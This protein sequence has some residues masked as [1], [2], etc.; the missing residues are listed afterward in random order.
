MASILSSDTCIVMLQWPQ[1]QIPATK[2]WRAHVMD[3]WFAPYSTEPV[4]KAVLTEWKDTNWNIYIYISK[5]ECSVGQGMSKLVL[6]QTSPLKG[7][8]RQG[9]LTASP[10]QTPCNAFPDTA[11]LGCITA[12]ISAWASLGCAE[13]ASAQSWN[14]HCV[15]WENP[16]GAGQG[17]NPLPSSNPAPKPCSC[18]NK[19]DVLLTWEMQWDFCHGRQRSWGAGDVSSSLQPKQGVVVS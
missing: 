2:E 6:P 12:P 17:Q 13:T 4:I 14:Q 18:Q 16:C 15:L 9:Q 3:S 1:K 8:I 19:R 11:V 10:R 5:I 7:V